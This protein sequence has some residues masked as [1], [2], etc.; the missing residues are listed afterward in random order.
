MCVSSPC[1]PPPRPSFIRSGKECFLLFL[2]LQTQELHPPELA[3]LATPPFRWKV[4]SK[5][6]Q[7]LALR[8]CGIFAFAHSI[9]SQW[10]DFLLF[11][12]QL[13]ISS[14]ETTP[15]TSQ[16]VDYPLSRLFITPGVVSIIHHHTYWT[17]GLYVHYFQDFELPKHKQLSLSLS[18]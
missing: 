5:I 16:V 14:S 17:V 18:L 6:K 10:N 4:M 2:L 15:Y 8:G 12:A 1:N 13:S 3:A 9:P 7:L 11:S